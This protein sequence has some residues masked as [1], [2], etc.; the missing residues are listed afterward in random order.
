MTEYEVG[1]DPLTGCEYC[2]TCLQQYDNL[3][4][5]KHCNHNKKTR[6]QE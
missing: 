1:Y 3:E 5:A 6:T 4:E 2:L